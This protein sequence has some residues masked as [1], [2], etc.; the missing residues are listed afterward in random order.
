M[1]TD[2]AGKSTLA[3]RLTSALEK[4]GLRS[5]HV[6]LGAESFLL[7]PIRFL[8]RPMVRRRVR[9]GSLAETVS[10]Q[11]SQGAYA[12]TAAAK[13]SMA[14][15]WPVMRSLYIALALLDYRLQYWLKMRRARDTEVVVADRYLFD[16][17]VNI[18]VATGM[19]PEET[20]ALARRVAS[21]FRFPAA[22]YYLRAEPA[23]SLQRKDDI[24]DASYLALRLRHYDA[25][26]KAFPFEWLDAARPIELA[27]EGLL[28]G[29]R[30]VADQKLV[31]FV[32]SNNIDLGGADRV[33]VSLA[34]HV[35][36][37]PT[38]PLRALVLLRQD[39]SAARL[40]ALAGTAALLSPFRRP[41]LSGGVFRAV[42]V[43]ITWPV[44]I[45]RLVRVIRAQDPDVVH[46]NDLYDF[47][48]SLAAKLCGVPVVHHVRMIRSG[49]GQ[50]RLVRAL[51]GGVSDRVVSV[52]AAVQKAYVDPAGDGSSP[53]RVIHDHARPELWVESAGGVER[54]AS[55]AG[56]RS[57][58]VMLG[59]IEPWKGQH[60]F[61]EA[62]AA[63]PQATREAVDFAI[64]G[65]TVPGKEQ[66]AVEIAAAAERLGVRYLGEVED[67][68]GLL[69]NS[70]VAVHAST[71]PDPFPGTVVEALLAGCAV[72]GAD[73]GGV[74]ELIP[75]EQVGLRF[76]SGDARSL[77]DRLEAILGN[78]SP[79]REQFSLAV[80]HARTLTD[81]V[82][83]DSE[84]EQLYLEL[85]DQQSVRPKGAL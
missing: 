31:L 60:V 77:S 13:A 69:L 45:V 33:L 65:G 79:P 6:W 73:D 26:A 61:L 20:V 12:E 59:R 58:V 32:H 83:I 64:A 2:G 39:G 76:R 75:N 50:R 19:E 71:E 41:Q 46:V 4:A 7:A 62:V 43:S 34:E 40:H 14:R 82:R 48:P 25:I 18:A 10:A 24:P 5:H 70:D 81:P 78:N 57:L 55:L 15:R 37:L 74:R 44:S 9:G 80:S 52:S 67:V 51:L 53:W 23:L 38:L 66:Y 17:V 84:L 47:L 1:G 35:R 85:L 36:G 28:P 72:V 63:L 56:D 3:D 42:L 29:V 21:K 27:V 16:V 8:L 68:R 11:P 49:R 30:A 54:P 22:L